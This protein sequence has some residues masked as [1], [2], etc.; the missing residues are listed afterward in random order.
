MPNTAISAK[1][2]G[3][4]C[5]VPA[6]CHSL[7]RTLLGDYNPELHALGRETLSWCIATE[8]TL[9]SCSRTVF[10]WEQKEERLRTLDLK[11]Q[12]VASKVLHLL[13]YPLK[14]QY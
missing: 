6:V 4:S 10:W 9:Y 7:Y 12:W 1:Q 2:L 11:S 13:L 3:G 14:L 5:A 8:I